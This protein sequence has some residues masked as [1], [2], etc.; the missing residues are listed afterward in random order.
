MDREVNSSRLVARIQKK[1]REGA[2]FVLDVALHAPPGI[3]ILFG[4]SGAG[5]ST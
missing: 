4:P 2:S 3:T 5:K 1:R